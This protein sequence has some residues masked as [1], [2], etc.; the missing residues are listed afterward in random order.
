[1]REVLRK[2]H[3]HHV[4]EP[5][6]TLAR[7]V[8]TPICVVCMSC[9]T[10]ILATHPLRDAGLLNHAAEHHISALACVG[11]IAALVALHRNHAACRHQRTKAGR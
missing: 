3:S 7:L 8:V 11:N 2:E 10:A 5:R 6:H 1:M 4:S 9:C